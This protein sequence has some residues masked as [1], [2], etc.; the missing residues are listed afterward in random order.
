MVIFII[1][2]R[3]ILICNVINI[4]FSIYLI[5]IYWKNVDKNVLNGIRNLLCGCKW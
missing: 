2:F 1:I 4:L 5:I 3:E